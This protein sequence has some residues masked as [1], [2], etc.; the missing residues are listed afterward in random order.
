MSIVA[1]SWMLESGLWIFLTHMQVSDV[2]FQVADAMGGRF[3]DTVPRVYAGRVV[4]DRWGEGR[5]EGSY[6]EWW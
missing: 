4:E 3:A 1:R 6:G 2:G 5:C